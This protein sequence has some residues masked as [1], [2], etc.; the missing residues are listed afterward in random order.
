MTNAAWRDGLYALLRVARRGAI[1]ALEPEEEQVIEA[2]LMTV[3]T[4]TEASP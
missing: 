3:F 2:I 4:A 1:L